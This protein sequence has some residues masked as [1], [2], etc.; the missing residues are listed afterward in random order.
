MHICELADFHFTWLWVVTH[1]ANLLHKWDIKRIMFWG[2]AVFLSP[3]PVSQK[4]KTDNSELLFVNL[5]LRRWTKVQ[6]SNNIKHCVSFAKYCGFEIS[7]F[8]T[9]SSY[10]LTLS[11]IRSF[12][13]NEDLCTLIGG[14][15]WWCDDMFD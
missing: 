9:V 8:V 13:L 3:Y 15:S 7:T 14:I 11:H 4:M 10:M 12:I 5:R 2:F 1:K 6:I